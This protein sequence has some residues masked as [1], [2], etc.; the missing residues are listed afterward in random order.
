MALVDRMVL[1]SGENSG[2][3]SPSTAGTAMLMVSTASVWA[4]ASASASA[5]ASP[6][7]CPE[8][9]QLGG[10]DAPA[11]AVAE[12]IR[13]R[14]A[15]SHLGTNWTRAR[16]SLAEACTVT[17]QD[18][19]SASAAASETNRGQLPDVGGDCSRNACPR[20]AG[21]TESI[22][23][24]PGAG[25]TSGRAASGTSSRPLSRS[26][27]R[28]ESGHLV[29][30][31]SAK[32]SSAFA[33][34]PKSVSVPVG[35]PPPH[36]PALAKRPSSTEIAATPLGKIPRVA[37]TF[38]ERLLTSG[39]AALERWVA[40]R[41]HARLA[42]RRQ[43]LTIDDLV[44][45]ATRSYAS[46]GA[47]DA[48]ARYSRQLVAQVA[49]EASLAAEES[50][51]QWQAVH[52][53]VAAV[54]AAATAG[55]P[56]S[57]G[58]PPP[59]S[60]MPS[61]TETSQ[62]WHAPP[63]PLRGRPASASPADL[64]DKSPCNRG[65]RLE[66][67]RQEELLRWWKE[68]ERVLDG[69]YQSKLKVLED[70]RE[71]SRRQ[72]RHREKN[73]AAF[74]EAER[75]QDELRLERRRGS[76]KA[77]EEADMRRQN[78]MAAKTAGPPQLRAA[79]ELARMQAARMERIREVERE[80]LR[81]R[82]DEQLASA[83]AAAAAPAVVADAHAAA[84]AAA[85]AATA[86]G[87]DDSAA[88]VAASGAAAAA[89]AAASR[90]RPST[91][92]TKTSCKPLPRLIGRRQGRRLPHGRSSA[93]SLG[94]DH[95]NG[96]ACGGGGGWD[97]M[98]VLQDGLPWIDGSFAALEASDMS[99]DHAVLAHFTAPP[100]PNLRVPAVTNSADAAGISKTKR[101]SPQVLSSEAARVAID[102]TT[103]ADIEEVDRVFA[104]AYTRA[105][106]ARAL[107]AVSLGR[108][109]S[110]PV[111]EAA[112]D[113]MADACACEVTPPQKPE[114]AFS[115]FGSAAIESTAGVPKSEVALPPEEAPEA[116]VEPR[117]RGD[118]AAAYVRSTRVG[119]HASAALRS[120]RRSRSTPL[121][122]SS[123][124]PRPVITE[125]D[126][127]IASPSPHRCRETALECS[128]S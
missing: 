5:G 57:T 107:V 28:P 115:P 11:P 117:A 81:H 19:P 68:R 36:A 77:Q 92:G 60:H 118:F 69:K 48:E 93:P 126:E 94:G 23:G 102:S 90:R 122:S 98:L 53:A 116:K 17:A 21:A 59:A 40:T 70:V 32:V 51:T 6:R 62:P 47:C 120:E 13:A 123:W 37:V 124:K 39:I 72:N 8:H 121:A 82:L 63:P 50:R 22:A 110:D 54:A 112:L 100:T 105:I 52:A 25:A 113:F 119:S 99:T 125:I 15:A 83:T 79:R 16:S 111:Q 7:G 38:A 106:V 86:A 34:L 84:T 85:T 41:E 108:D 88:A 101:S 31:R 35:S 97:A 66:L 44:S 80:V 3:S 127:Q 64:P 73:Y 71:R 58:M 14:P 95:G 128:V 109:E 114:S 75:R 30:P 20:A 61:T 55:A 33:R 29:G 10:S 27:S 67:D 1:P 18:I 24:P 89:I 26:S 87:A 74:L 42:L 43:G 56:P 4:S 76:Q 104:A 91:A 9:S 2:Y 46:T 49:W 65:L 96:G 103:T 78:I 12:A 45:A